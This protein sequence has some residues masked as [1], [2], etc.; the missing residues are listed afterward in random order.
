MP[1]KPANNAHP[2][3]LRPQ[4]PLDPH[5]GQPTPAGQR[6]RRADA[7]SVTPHPEA[8]SAKRPKTSASPVTPALPS[9][10]TAI[11]QDNRAMLR[12][13]SGPVSGRPAAKKIVIK[14]R[15]VDSVGQKA[16]VERY[17]E[18][19]WR[20]VEVA[21]QA[22]LEGRKVPMPLDRV[23][24]G[25][26]DLCRNGRE[27]DVYD[28]LFGACERHLTNTVLPAIKRESSQD[29]TRILG[30]VLSEWTA[31]NQKAVGI[32]FVFLGSLGSGRQQRDERG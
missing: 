26:E 2:N 28:R 22:V 11:H 13:Q 17:F 25:V 4:P 7:E 5:S 8:P 16:E 14:N 20:E 23:Y 32:P 1:S 31:F 12:V 30:A 29:D 10:T 27:K 3:Y 18:A 9:S 15:R 21:V 6:R 19:T 24:R